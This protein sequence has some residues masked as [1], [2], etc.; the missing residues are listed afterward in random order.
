MY[1]MADI[2]KTQYVRGATGEVVAVYENAV[3]QFDNILAG[4]E[5]IG[6][7]DGSQRRYFLKDHLG[8]VRTTVNRDGN[9]LGYDNYYPF[10][11]Q[12]PGRSSNSAN[13]N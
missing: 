2:I 10:G 3:K 11:L 5:I 8:N 7:W 12:M 1:D 9:V 13:P 6:T 4:S